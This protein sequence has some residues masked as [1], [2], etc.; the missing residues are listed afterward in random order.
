[1]SPSHQLRV[2]RESVCDVWRARKYKAVISKTPKGVLLGKGSKSLLDL[3]RVYL[4]LGIT[5]LK[6]NQQRIVI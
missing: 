2:G 5:T 6:C 4:R 3:L 1:M